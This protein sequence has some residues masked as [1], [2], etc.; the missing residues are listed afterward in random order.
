MAT[1]DFN[2]I[3]AAFATR[4]KELQDA[5]NLTNIFKGAPDVLV[6]KF[7]GSVAQNAP[8]QTP[9]EE[10]SLLAK[11]TGTLGTI[12][13]SEPENTSGKLNVEDSLYSQHLMLTQQL[14]LSG[15]PAGNMATLAATAKKAL[16][17]EIDS[18]KKDFE[19]L[20]KDTVGLADSFINVMEGI[21][22]GAATN[23]AEAL[24][25]ALPAMR[26]LLSDA[27]QKTVNLHSRIL[28]GKEFSGERM[29]SLISTLKGIKD[30][31][32]PSAF[33]FAPFFSG[34]SPQP[35][36]KID[37][38]ME[39]FQGI[40][41]K[42]K[43]LSTFRQDAL[44]VLK[45]GD[46]FKGNFSQMYGMFKQ[47]SGGL[48]AIAGQK[49]GDAAKGFQALDSVMSQVNTMTGMMQTLGNKKFRQDLIDEGNDY[50]K[51]FKVLEGE[52]ASNF[53]SVSGLFSVEDDLKKMRTDIRTLTKSIK[54][55][56][57]GKMSPIE[58][59][60][61]IKN[62]VSSIEETVQ[63]KVDTFKTALS[64]FDPKPTADA[65]AYVASVGSLA[66]TAA[67]AVFSGS[68]V[69]FEKTLQTVG[70]LTKY[71]QAI[72][73]IKNIT[74]QKKITLETASQLASLASKLGG[75]HKRQMQGM[76]SSNLPAWR[77]QLLK[78]QQI[79][80]N[81]SIAPYELLV[82]ILKGKIT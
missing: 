70:D 25:Q 62:S 33:A 45:P 16:S 26:T 20:R 34:S 27:Q 78:E 42:G 60:L 76:M 40:V 47:M 74:S 54:D 66:P 11:A 18:F 30:S 72:Q 68:M 73:E 69:N 56:A 3:V 82:K 13:S 5:V 39:Q 15:S 12:F 4:R 55:A 63:N 19:T 21:E 23:P 6:S 67:E 48:S 50:V 79:F 58:A 52:L 51:Q 46:L 14:L 28:S 65:T 59:I 64:I 17:G 32:A 61:N 71:G 22:P 7:V 49:G 24:Q 44:N 35:V 77:S 36:D 81:K 41:Q 43:N 80:A 38:L 31:V 57:N 29:D 9:E 37:S 10:E 1:I 75:L 8:T 53:G 2:K